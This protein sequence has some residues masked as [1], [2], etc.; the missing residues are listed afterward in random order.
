MLLQV[1]AEDGEGGLAG[2]NRKQRCLQGE[3][4]VHAILLRRSALQ[5]VSMHG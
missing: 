5:A 1:P 3:V 4:L 2:D